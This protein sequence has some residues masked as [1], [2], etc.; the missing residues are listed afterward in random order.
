MN[1]ASLINF[2]L[3][4]SREQSLARS[5]SERSEFTSSAIFG[6]IFR[7]I[8]SPPRRIDFFGSF[9]IKTK[10]T[11]D[12]SIASLHS[13]IDDWIPAFAGMTNIV[14]FSET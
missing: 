14:L 8:Y 7:E 3:R 4:K 11:R 1:K 5:M 6:V 9:C 13:D 2:P 10:R 12:A